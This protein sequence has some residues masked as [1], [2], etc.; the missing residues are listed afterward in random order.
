MSES[1][2]LDWVLRDEKRAMGR[3]ETSL[4]NTVAFT[5]SIRPLK[6][7]ELTA[8]TTLIKKLSS[9]DRRAVRSVN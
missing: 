1:E 2:N 6:N 5:Q 9:Q 7:R 3:K 8:I 4:A